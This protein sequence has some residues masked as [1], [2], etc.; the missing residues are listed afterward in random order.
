MTS[1]SSVL[2]ACAVP[3]FQ[4]TLSRPT[5]H[6]GGPLLCS[7]FPLSLLRC[8]LSSNQWTFPR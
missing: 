5:R 1:D 8:T 7:E 2:G 3:T 4:T 6:A